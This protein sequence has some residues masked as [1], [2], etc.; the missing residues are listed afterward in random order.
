MR[1]TDEQDQLEKEKARQI[2]AEV[3]LIPEVQ[4]IDV[5]L[6]TDNTGDPALQLIFR[7]KPEVEVDGTFIKR[8]N[9]FAATVQ[10]RI[11]HSDIPRFPYARIRQ[12]A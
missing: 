10:T 2:V 9:T 11:L 4:S 8:F 3:P 12:V 7:I 6:Y 5:E 1:T